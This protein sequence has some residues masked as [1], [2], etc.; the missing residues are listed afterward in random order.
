MAD[1]P[2]ALP[3]GTRFGELEILRTLGVGGFGIVYLARDHAL[4]RDVAIKEYMPGQ[5]AQRGEGSMVSVRSGPL[6]E[7]FEI[8]RRSFVNEARLLARFDHRSLIKVHQFWEAN[9]TAYM[10]MPYLQGQTLKQARQAMTET[11][12]EAWMLWLLLPL[13]DGLRVLHEASV[14]HR[15]IAP[16]NILLP[17]NGDDAILLDFGAARRA[18]GDNTQ[19]L[20]AILKPSYAPIE[21]YAESTGLRQGP[22]TD[23]Y[24]LGAVLH[25]LVLGRAPP[26]ATMRTVVDDYQPLQLMTLPGLSPAFRA[27]ID[28][29]LRVR[30]ADRPQ[31]IADL[32]AA[33][34]GKL[35]PPEPLASR[36]PAPG[37]PAEALSP[38]GQPPVDLDLTVI[39]PR[40]PVVAPSTSALSTPAGSSANPATN[41]PALPPPVAAV[42]SPPA[43]RP[44]VLL[45]A[46]LGAAVLVV[47]GAWWALRSGGQA[48]PVATQ[49]TQPTQATAATVT[50]TTAPGPA[51][52]AS[53]LSPGVAPALPART[54]PTSPVAQADTTVPPKPPPAVATRAEPKAKL[55]AAP[56]RQA[57]AALGNSAPAH[58]VVEPAPQPAAPVVSDPVARASAPLPAPAPAPAAPSDPRAACAD[59]NLLTRAWCVDQRCAKPAFA[60]HPVCINLREIREQRSRP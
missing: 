47:G 59:Q 7:T 50:A 45:A 51:L 55:P 30:P 26:P 35:T 3:V 60:A 6:H 37:R 17:G 4:E 48:D 20:T 43:K 44:P 38:G 58:A 41:P 14:F 33:L 1:T 29:A 54:E 9:G 5:L 23:I 21:Q 24:A 8:G 16:D 42:A 27:A 56:T 25:T 39:L 34:L 49:S 32:R 13:L 18:I 40:P 19:A 10:A 11:P 31:S 52:P 28:W 53:V 36:M 15:D 57:T 46:L 12:S 2:N 22:W